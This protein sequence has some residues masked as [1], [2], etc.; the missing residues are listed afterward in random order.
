MNNTLQLWLWIASHK[1]GRMESSESASL[2]LLH[3]AMHLCPHYRAVGVATLQGEGFSRHLI[4]CSQWGILWA[5]NQSLV[6]CGK[7]LPDSKS[8]L[9]NQSSAVMLFI[10]K[11]QRNGQVSTATSHHMLQFFCS[12]QFFVHAVV[13]KPGLHSHTTG[14]PGA[15]HVSAGWPRPVASYSAIVNILGDGGGV[16]LTDILRGYLYRKH[17]SEGRS[18]ICGSR[19]QHC[20]TFVKLSRTQVSAEMKLV[21]LRVRS[22]VPKVKS[23]STRTV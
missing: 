11:H 9:T 2:L 5:V 21:R 10:R 14:R 17:Q 3:T 13:V 16:S 23:S 4:Q 22:P 6:I 8:G 18:Y 15:A 19:F 20:G 12:W 1:K 7:W